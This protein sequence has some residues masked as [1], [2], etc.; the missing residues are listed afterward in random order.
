MSKICYKMSKLFFLEWNNLLDRKKLSTSIYNDEISIASTDTVYG[1]LAN[2]TEQ[3]FKKLIELKG[4]R[5]DKPFIILINSQ[6][7]LKHFID[8]K[9]LTTATKNIIDNCWPGPLTIIFRAKKNLS[10]FLK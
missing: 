7:K 5:L 8:V 6:E 4:D 9:K 2:I 1:F 10:T 3:S